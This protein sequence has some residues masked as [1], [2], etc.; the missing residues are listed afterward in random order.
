MSARDVRAVQEGALLTLSPEEMRC[1]VADNTLEELLDMEVGDQ[2]RILAG[3]IRRRMRYEK[4]DALTM[5]VAMHRVPWNILVS[6]ARAVKATVREGGGAHKDE[7]KIVFWTWD[8]YLKAVNVRERMYY[9][10]HPCKLHKDVE[11][12]DRRKVALLISANYPLVLSA[13]PLYHAVSEDAF[14]CMLVT[15]SF[16]HQA[17]NERG[18]ALNYRPGHS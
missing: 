1:I 17:W 9:T 7:V 3:R 16:K 13:H 15:V 12:G 6:R 10:R 4:S 14:R 11:G 18:L 8:S 5:T 2:L